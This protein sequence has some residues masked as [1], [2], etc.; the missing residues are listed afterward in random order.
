MGDV[1]SNAGPSQE[2]PNEPGILEARPPGLHVVDPIEVSTQP[3]PKTHT[4]NTTVP[5]TATQ[6]HK[7]NTKRNQF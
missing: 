3:P 4:P 2:Y 1:L 5:S 6:N 7:S